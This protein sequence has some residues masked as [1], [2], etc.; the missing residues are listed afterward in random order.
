MVVDRNGNPLEVGQKI[1]IFYDDQEPKDA[2]V[3]KIFEDVPTV[4]QAGYWLDVDTGKG[5]EGMMSYRVEI[6]S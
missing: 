5:P 3:L 1:R 4:L 2:I 6:L